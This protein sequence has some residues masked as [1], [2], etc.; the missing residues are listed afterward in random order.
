MG[1]SSDW[2]GKDVIAADGE[3]IGR[4][5]ARVELGHRDPSSRV[6]KSSASVYGIGT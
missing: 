2:V 4:V 6:L 5:K 1:T 3:R